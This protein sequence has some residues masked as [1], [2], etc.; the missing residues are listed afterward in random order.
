MSN[1]SVIKD[2]LYDIVAK[3][4]S[5]KSND[6]KFQQNIDRYM[7]ANLPSYASPGPSIRPY[8]QQTDVASLIQVTGLT[9]ELIKETLG[10][11]KGTNADW[12]NANTPFNIAIVLA[13]RYYT[14]Q[15]N[16]DRINQGLLYMIAH[17]YAF[18]YF[19]YFKHRPNEAAMAYTIANMSY[20]FKLKKFGTLLGALVD[21]TRIC[22]DTHKDRIIRGN[23]IDNVKFINDVTTRINSF[24]KTIRDEFGTNIKNKNY[25]QSE[26]DEIGED[27]YYEAD[28]DVYAIDRIVNKILT[29]LVVNGP[30]RSIINLAASNSQVSKNNMQTYTMVLI[31]EQNREDIR[32]MLE[33]LILLYLTNN[34]D[35]KA[36][37]RDIGSN[38]FFLYCLRVYRQSNT[39]DKNIIQ[40]KKI[41]DKW[42]DDLGIAQQIGTP[43]GIGN[44]RK[45]I[46]TFF[47]FT[48]EKNN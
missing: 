14:L 29:T 8:F 33:S 7:A 40:I 38:K 45:A 36:S 43:T 25:L 44:Y 10:K 23:D 5:D 18:M 3:S 9:P 2:D 28:S 46:F 32:Q 24:I 21:I 41:L 17:I 15:K 47:V 48:I 16:E 13:I 37:L 35:S 22:Y 34:P 27:V 26:H 30:D 20:R 6:L 39:S 4:L 12:K 42:I 11:I 1:T 31:S 19:K